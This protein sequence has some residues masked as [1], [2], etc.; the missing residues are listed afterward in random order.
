MKLVDGSKTS[1]KWWS[2]RLM[3]AAAI[4]EGLRAVV[5]SWAGILPEGWDVI[6]S[7]ILITA[8]MIARLIKQEVLNA[9]MD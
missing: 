1:H 8:A 9:E 5:P 3:A 6:I 7:A 2:M 4:F